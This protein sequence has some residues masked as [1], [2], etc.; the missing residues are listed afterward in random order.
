MILDEYYR[1]LSF[2]YICLVD[3][4]LFFWFLDCKIFGIVCFEDFCKD[5]ID[6]LVVGKFE[7][8]FI[9]LI[10]MYCFKEVKISLL[11]VSL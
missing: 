10:R 3:G 8:K 6:L 5:Y 11:F 9:L 7:I 2:N 4:R 1:N